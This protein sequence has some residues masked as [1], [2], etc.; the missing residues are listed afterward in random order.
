[1]KKYS[2]NFSI[3]AKE[4]KEADSKM[5]ALQVLAQELNEKE[6]AK[7]ADIVKNDPL[8]TALAKSYLGL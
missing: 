1:M 7:L 4:G 3:T 6:L 2:Y 8:K 5:K